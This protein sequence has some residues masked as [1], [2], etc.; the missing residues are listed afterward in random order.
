MENQLESWLS[1]LVAAVALRC[2][3]GRH[4]LDCQVVVN[5]VSL[6]LFA[7]DTAIQNLVA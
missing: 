1:Q 7:V 4:M 5:E 6:Q 2:E 3:I